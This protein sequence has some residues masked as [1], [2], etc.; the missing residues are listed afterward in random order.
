MLDQL[1]G[2]VFSY[3]LC[4]YY[5]TLDKQIGNC[6]KPGNLMHQIDRHHYIYFYYEDRVTNLYLQIPEFSIDLTS[7]FNIASILR[8][9]NLNGTSDR[10]WFAEVKVENEQIFILK[11]ICLGYRLLSHL[12][13]ETNWHFLRFTIEKRDILYLL[14]MFTSQGDLDSH[15]QYI[16]FRKYPFITQIELNI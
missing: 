7:S 2:L 8:R 10:R 16:A 13:P 9:S 3:F 4:F 11:R 1:S 14:S 6:Y 5:Y 15:F 12:R